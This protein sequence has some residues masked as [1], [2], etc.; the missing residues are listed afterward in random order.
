MFKKH[1][2]MIIAVLVL[3][4]MVAGCAAPAAAPAAPAADAAAAIVL[5]DQGHDPSEFGSTGPVIRFETHRVVGLLTL[6]IKRDIVGKVS[7]GGV[8]QQLLVRGQLMPHPVCL[9][10]GLLSSRRCMAQA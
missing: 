9:S 7:R 3:L 8:A 2:S 4:S 6:A 5:A 1:L 10:I